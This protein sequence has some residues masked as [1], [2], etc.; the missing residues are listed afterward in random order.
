M[1]DALLKSGLKVK[2]FDVLT[3]YTVTEKPGRWEVHAKL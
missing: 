2:L 3:G 1:T